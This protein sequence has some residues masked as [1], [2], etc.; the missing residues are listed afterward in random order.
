MK[1][2]D[3]I[4]QIVIGTNNGRRY[5]LHQIT[6]PNIRVVTEQ[7]DRDGHYTFYN[8][9]TINGDPFSRGTLVFENAALAA[10]FRQ[11]YDAHCR[12]QDGYLE[13]YGYWMRRD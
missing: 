7:P 13:E 6:A 12:S 11:A 1:L 10:P 5:R 2:A 8:C 9:P 4:G 3:F